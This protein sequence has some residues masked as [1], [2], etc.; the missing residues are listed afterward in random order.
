MTDKQ[1]ISAAG[2]FLSPGVEEAGKV[3]T[4][5]V[6]SPAGTMIAECESKAIADHIVKIHNL[7]T[8]AK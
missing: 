3:I 5:I 7:T 2:W 6:C 8:A 4:W 1:T